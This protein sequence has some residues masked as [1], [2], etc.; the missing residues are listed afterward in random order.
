MSLSTRL[1]LGY[2]LLIVV[3]LASVTGA[4]L[5]FRQLASGIDTV[6]KENV[7]SVRIAARLLE[8]L[9]RHNGSLFQVLSGGPQPE[10]VRHGLEREFRDALIAARGNVS[11]AGEV[12]L[13]KGIEET[14]QRFIET[15]ARLL[16]AP[17]ADPLPQYDREVAPAL[18]AC[19]A[20]LQ[21]LLDMNTL[22]IG[23]A[24]RDARQL[25]GQAGTVLAALAAAALML[26]AMVSSQMHRHLLGP[27]A[28]MQQAA[29]A[30]AAGDSRRR[31]PAAGDSELGRLATQLNAA[32]TSRDDT[33][34]RAK[35]LLAQ[36]RQL[37]IGLLASLAE[38]AALVGLDGGVVASTLGDD[39]TEVLATSQRSLRAAWSGEVRAEIAHTH[40]LSLSAGESFRLKL[41]L[42]PPDRA[43]GWLVQ[44]L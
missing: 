10:Q 20:K 17:E 39:A 25:A 23:V 42:A 36:Q 40:T 2:G 38:P 4:A 29:E 22:A 13:I 28:V 27:L 21:Q 19:R 35:G 5:I 34:G 1:M 32:L 6:L 26:L 44:K 11:V 30:I 14:F 7:A 8:L 31:L 33:S 16:A 9:E 37:L 41:L 43:V 18:A 12:E 24:D 3:L 15:R